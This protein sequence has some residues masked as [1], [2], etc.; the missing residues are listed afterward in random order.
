[1]RPG[2]T[3]RAH[4]RSL[5]D[6]LEGVGLRATGYLLVGSD[7]RV[8][9]SYYA[10]GAE[11]RSGRGFAQHGDEPLEPPPASRRSAAT[12]DEIPEREPRV[13]APA[14]PGLGERDHEDAAS[15][16]PRRVAPGRAPRT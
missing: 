7:E 1:M 4:L 2:N 12:A 8:S 10:Y 14:D 13:V 5:R 11:V 3:D 16:P 6:L 9:R 15:E